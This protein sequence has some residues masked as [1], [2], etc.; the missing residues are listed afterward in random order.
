MRTRQMLAVLQEQGDQLV[1]GAHDAAPGFQGA[2][3]GHLELRRHVQALAH[4]LVHPLGRLLAVRRRRPGVR[5]VMISPS[6][7]L[8][9]C[10]QQACGV[11]LCFS[12]SCM[13]AYV[14]QTRNVLTL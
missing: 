14:F 6:F 8:H 2:H 11:S 9:G 1:C 5:A 7:W 3:R 12:T 10:L 4:P 13:R